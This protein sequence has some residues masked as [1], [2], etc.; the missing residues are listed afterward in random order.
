MVNKLEWCSPFLQSYYDKISNVLRFE[1]HLE[2]DV[3]SSNH[4]ALAN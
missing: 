4:E 2:I 3:G 1:N